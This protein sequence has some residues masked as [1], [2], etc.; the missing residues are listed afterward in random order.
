MYGYQ[1]YARGQ[2]KAGFSGYEAG[3]GVAP[4]AAATAVTGIVGKV[5]NLV[6]SIFGGGPSK[7]QLPGG[8]EY[9]YRKATVLEAD[10]LARQE[11][12]ANAVHM[13]GAMGRVKA[14]P[15]A[16]PGGFP[17]FPKRPKKTSTGPAGETYGGP[18]AV[19]YMTG[20]WGDSFAPIQK[21]AADDYKELVST[22]NYGTTVVDG[23][24]P[25]GDTGSYG[26]STV[27]PALAFSPALLVIGLGVAAAVLMKKR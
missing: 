9:E 12:N 16:I 18:K 4:I 8:T 10:R 5:G 1:M 27:Q 15:V 11:N 26:G 21:Y 7:E 17:T 25:T 19:G 3:L 20:K 13:L 23:G 6:G 22:N 2:G 24:T 14:L